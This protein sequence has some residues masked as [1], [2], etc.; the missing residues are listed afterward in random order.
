MGIAE[1]KARHNKSVR[2]S[3]LNAARQIAL[4]TGWQTVS[5]R[6]IASRIEYSTGII[7]Q[8]FDG[9][10]EVLQTLQ[11]DGFKILRRKIADAQHTAHEPE[12]VIINISLAYWQFSYEYRELYQVMFNLEGVFCDGESTTREIKRAAQPVSMLLQ[13]FVSDPELQEEVFFH[14]WA[15]VHGFISVTMSGQFLQARDQN[16]AYLRRSLT[17]FVMGLKNAQA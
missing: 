16:E 3:I 10:A 2:A 11:A 9:K 5:V 12:L 6:R 17:R 7:Y 4:E 15:L 8:H 13:G 14:W 1:R